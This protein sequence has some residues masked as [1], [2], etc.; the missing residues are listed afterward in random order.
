MTICSARLSASA[1]CS[2]HPKS[3]FG[4][5]AAAGPFSLPRFKWPGTAKRH[6]TMDIR[7]PPFTAAAGTV[8]H[9][10]TRYPA[11][12]DGALSN[13]RGDFR[14]HHRPNQVR[15]ATARTCPQ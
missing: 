14:S 11:F 15:V 13:N 9:F 1:A 6:R 7:V 5:G 12:S 8:G 3:I 2:P 4:S 10:D